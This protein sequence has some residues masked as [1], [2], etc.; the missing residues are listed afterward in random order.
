MSWSQV[1]DLRGIIGVHKDEA[2]PYDE[3]K[4]AID[5]PK[6]LVPGEKDFF[7]NANDE[8]LSQLENSVMPLE[9]IA[10][11]VLQAIYQRQQAEISW[12]ALLWTVAEL[13][14]YWIGYD[15]P[16]LPSVFQINCGGLGGGALEGDIPPHFHCT[17]P[18]VGD[19][20]VY[21]P[22]LSPADIVQDESY[23][24]AAGC[25]TGVHEVTTLFSLTQDPCQKWESLGLGKATQMY[26]RPQQVLKAAR[27]LPAHRR[28]PHKASL[29][30]LW[31]KLLS[32]QPMRLIASLPML[33]CLRQG[34]RRMRF[35]SQ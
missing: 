16:P 19:S 27:L 30:G 1:A 12:I 11:Q 33:S 21:G 24:V 2:C 20:Q 29:S 34:G 7:L 31:W 5:H 28:L 22:S 3:H 13:N 8:L 35:T 26:Q 9:S 32:L 18:P 6:G 10:T 4:A 14:Q 17:C 23:A 25:S 15:A